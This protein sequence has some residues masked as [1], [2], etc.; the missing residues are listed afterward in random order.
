MPVVFVFEKSFLE[1][2]KNVQLL[3]EIDCS[4]FHIKAIFRQLATEKKNFALKVTLEMSQNKE[5]PIWTSLEI[6]DVLP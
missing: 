4:G 6:N 1:E 3:Y 2:W 5:S